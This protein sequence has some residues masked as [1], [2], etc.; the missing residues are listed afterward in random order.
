AGQIATMM[1][2]TGWSDTKGSAGRCDAY[3][4]TLQVYNQWLEEFG[5][6]SL[7]DQEIT[8]RLYDFLDTNRQRFQEESKFATVP[9]NR[10]GFIKPYQNK[11]TYIIHN[12]VWSEEI[13]KGLSVKRV[14]QVLKEHSIL[15]DNSSVYFDKQ[16]TRT[17][18]VHYHH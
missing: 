13:F 9:T 12:K 4:M 1:G 18:T 11:F 17:Y 14:N 15:I 16:K 5:K 3:C 6:E 8:T 7:E 2:V 10:A